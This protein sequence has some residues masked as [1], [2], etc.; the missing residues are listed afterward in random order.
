MTLVY[1]L[2]SLILILLAY[3]IYCQHLSPKVDISDD[4]LNKLNEKLL[5]NLDHANNSLV[6]LAS[7]KLD[8][9]K[10]EIEND[11]TNKRDA[12][13]KMVRTVLDE[14]KQQAQKLEQAEKNRVGSF[15]SLRESIDNN[16]KITEQ[17]SVTT[18]GLRKVLSNNQMRGAF[19]E[20]AAEDLLKMSGFVRGVDYEFNRQIEG[21]GSRPDFAVFLPDGVRINVDA[22][23]P[24][25]NLV[26]MAETD[27][28]GAKREY[29]KNFER[30]VKEKIHQVCT[31]D[32][33]DPGN[34]TVDFVILFIPNEMIFSYIYDKMPEVWHEA[35]RRKV[36]F[37]GPFS[38]TAILR[39][40]RQSY[41]NFH[42]Q[43]NI[44][45]IINL[46]HQFG[47]E[48]D[49]Y[50]TEFVKIGS[51]IDSLSRQYNLVN[52]TR[53]N[54][55]LRVVDKIKIDSEQARELPQ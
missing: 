20:K 37:C 46:I 17:L 41:D 11:L 30:D 31:R 35:I 8:S 10:Q 28:P 26:K 5:H 14:M 32:Y 34:N 13:E 36:V 29:A 48:F 18:E 12:I 54:Q 52:T 1:L 39:M 24:Y 40:I 7:Q 9:Q 15:E 4:F 53:T 16:R 50:N 55:L 25:P 33:I 49:K 27:D 22:K 6:T 42:Y 47:K 23:F 19:G 38:F 21:G 44:L 51:K 3:F 45:Q 2:L 43:K